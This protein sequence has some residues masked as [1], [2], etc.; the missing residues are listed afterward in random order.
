[1]DL[2]VVGDCHGQKPEIPD[3]NFDLVLAVGDICGGTEEMREYMFE[4]RGEDEEWYEMMGEEKAREEAE[5]SLEEGREILEQLD[6]LE[7]PVLVVPGNWDWSPENYP[8][9][10][11]LDSDLFADMVGEFEGVHLVDRE[12]FDA[13]ELDVVGYGP[14]SSPE[15]PQYED[16]EPETD[17]E[18]EEMKADY[19]ETLEELQQLVDQSEKPIILLSHNVPQGTSL[20]EIDNED[21]PVHGRHYGSL[22]VRE[23]I[24][25]ENVFLCAAGHI[26]EGEGTEELDE[27]LCVNTGLNNLVEIE[28]EDGEVEELEFLSEVSE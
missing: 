20:D 1:M 12:I 8:D 16:D 23:L 19:Q 11:Y 28:V 17:E 22:V 4:S 7:A 21:S 10:D 3:K 14:C 13:G 2:L 25:D 27:T 9:W 5:K 24:R 15:V 18:L 26:H 6:G